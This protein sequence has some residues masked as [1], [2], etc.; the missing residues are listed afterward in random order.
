MRKKKANLPFYRITQKTFFFSLFHFL[1]FLLIILK[2]VCRVGSYLMK[3]CCYLQGAE[4][5]FSIFVHSRP[6]FLLNKATTRSE[7]FLNR[8][9]NDSIQVVIPTI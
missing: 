4:S 5:R 8:Q 1:D 2:L 6:G 7:Y 3:H 9:V